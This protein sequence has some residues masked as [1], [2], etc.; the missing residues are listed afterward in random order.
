MKNANEIPTDV[1]QNDYILESDD[2]R[3]RT[4]AIRKNADI[5]DYFFHIRL[6][7][8]LALC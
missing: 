8:I 2:F 7:V 5:V 1:N 3:L 4:E 6:K